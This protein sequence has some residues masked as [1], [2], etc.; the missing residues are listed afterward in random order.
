MIRVGLGAVVLL[1]A[2]SASA[3]APTYAGY[4]IPG[5]PLVATEAAAGPVAVRDTTAPPDEW[6]GYDKVLHAGGSLLLTLSGQYVLVDKAGLSNGEA[7]PLSASTTLLL[8]VMKEVADSRRPRHPHFSW[9]DLVADAV[10]V[11]V[12]AA[13]A[14]L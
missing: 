7:L 6:L 1:G 3:Q 2:A 10:G 9:R 12:A 13:V 8:G 14:S 11:L 4:E 5:R